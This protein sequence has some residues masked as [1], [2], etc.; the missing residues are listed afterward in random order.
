MEIPGEEDM[1][2]SLWAWRMVVRRGGTEKRRTNDLEH[3]FPNPQ[4]FEPLLLV[5]SENFKVCEVPR[6]HYGRET[7]LPS[8]ILWGCRISLLRFP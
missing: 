3:P 7:C 2:I 4:S 5:D 6:S 8:A 1:D